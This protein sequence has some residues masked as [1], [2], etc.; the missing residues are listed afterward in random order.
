MKE[1]KSN[2]EVCKDHVEF[3][4]ESQDEYRQDHIHSVYGCKEMKVTIE[5]ISVGKKCTLFKINVGKKDI[6]RER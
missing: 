2:C 5:D 3:R 1:R 6:R 4:F